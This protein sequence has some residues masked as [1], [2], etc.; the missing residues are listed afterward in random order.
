MAEITI[1]ILHGPEG[2]PAFVH[3]WSMSANAKA[4]VK[5]RFRGGETV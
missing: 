2:A 3:D 4:S 1:R 5:C